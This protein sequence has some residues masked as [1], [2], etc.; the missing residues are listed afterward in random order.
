MRKARQSSCSK[1]TRMFVVLESIMFQSHDATK[2][3][4]G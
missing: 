3:L 1:D 2:N 4:V